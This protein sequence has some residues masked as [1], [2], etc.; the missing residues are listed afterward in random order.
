MDQ[1][2][3]EAEVAVEADGGVVVGLDVE[4]ADGEAL[5][6]QPVEAGERQ[7][8]AEAP[9]VR[10][11]GR[12]RS[13]RSRRAAGRR[14]RA[15]SSSRTPAEAGRRCV[16]QQEAVG[17]E[18]RLGHP[19]G[20]RSSSVQPPC[21]GCQAKARL[22][23][24]S[25]ASSS[26]PGDGTAARSEAAPSRGRR[27]GT[28]SGRR[29]WR[30][31]AGQCEAGGR[32]DRVELVGRRLGIEHEPAPRPRPSPGRPPGPRP[33]QLVERR[34][35]VGHRRRRSTQASQVRADRSGRGRRT[36][37][38]SSRRIAGHTT[39]GR[40]ACPSR[41]HD[42]ERRR[43]GPARRTERLA[44]EYPDARVRARPPQRLRA[45]GGHDPVGADAPT[46]G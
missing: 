23:T 8:P 37:R 14:R 32:G 7:G 18:P 10:S 4:H 41:W 42:R 16:V 30:S 40:V 22:L 27:L 3:G 19:R 29:S 21:S 2:L 44:L 35:R 5:V 34:A 6:G 12:R 28:G 45:P 36:G 31:V 15:P 43:A 33:G 13:R 20:A 26:L 38:G 9:A 24:A 39:D 17:V 25:Q 46:S 11:R 1:V